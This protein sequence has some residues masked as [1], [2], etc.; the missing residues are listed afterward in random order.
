MRT[1]V[2]V[3]GMM[4]GG[5]AGAVAGCFLGVHVSCDWLWPNSN[6]CGLPG[7]FVGGP[8][9]LLGGVVFVRRLLL[10]TNAPAAAPKRPSRRKNDL[11]SLALVLFGVIVV[12]TYQFKLLDSPLV[13]LVFVAMAVFIVYF[14]AK[15]FPASKP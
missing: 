3:L 6:M 4:L 11:E 2:I 15:S 12:V 13:L 7:I 9:G 5:V 14:F 8:A 1:L 10:G